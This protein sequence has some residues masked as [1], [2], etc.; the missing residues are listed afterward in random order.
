VAR[1][2]PLANIR[3]IGVVAH[4]DAGKTT[5]TERL[6]Y[7]SGRVH[8]IGEVD[9][10]SAT[11]DWMI[12][13]QER[14]ITIT[15]AATSI[16][17]RE[18]RIN[19]IDTPGHVDF[20]MEVE[21]SL[22]VLDGAIVIFCAKGGVEPQ[23]ETVWRQADRYRVPRI[24]YINKMDSVGA[25][26]DSAVD[27]MR[28]KLKANPLPVQL[29]I[30]AEG[31]FRGAVDLVEMQAL[32]FSGEM[33][34]QVDRT[35]IPAE[36]LA[37]A[38]AA[39][40]RLV[41]AV[42]EIDE[43][44]LAPYLDGEEIGADALRAA[45]RR[46]TLAVKGIP[47]FCGTSLRNKGVQPLI[48]GVVDYLPAPSDLP[49]VIG[50]HPRTEEDES[51]A[52]S[53]EEPFAALVFKI[54]TDPYVGKLS[55]IRVYS[56]HVETGKTVWNPRTRKR[57]RL[58]RLVRMHANHRA[59]ITELNTGDVVAAVG[60]RELTTGD[61]LCSENNPILLEQ[62]QYPE[63]VISVAIEPDTKAD[64]ERL[65]LSLN[66]LAEEDPTF[67]Y[68]TDQETGQQIISGMG[69]LH[70]DIIVDRLVREF[71]VAARVGRPQVSYRE[72]IQRPAQAEARYVRQTGGRGQF[73]HVELQIVPRPD[74]TGFTFKDATKGGV[75]PGE[76]LP[77]VEAG[78]REAMSAGTQGF[79][80]IG[81]DVSLVNGSAHEVDSSP[82]AFRIAASMAFRN[83]MAK[84]TPVLLE[85]MMLVEVVIPEEYLGEVLADLS[86]RRGSIEDVGQGTGARIIDATVPLSAMFGYA[87]DLRSLTQGR[88]TFTMQFARY[89]LLPPGSG[90]VAGRASSR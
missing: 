30:G 34:A 9:Q 16:E 69:E 35:E 66:K 31:D 14:G 15:S 42:A 8:R 59:D 61:T 20:T 62:M 50:K 38:K 71:G 77:D 54:A 4:I 81:V 17:W 37:P 2:V 10:G 3:N 89:N 39:R 85:P 7:Y 63:P 60:M 46:I 12:Q 19:V 87:T 53:D 28:R 21:R 47:V 48:D 36:Y 67:R 70:L 49:P 40:E 74:L 26:F 51:R 6:L 90:P 23:S 79:P 84:A 24:A 44:I 76:F 75:V 41:E 72:T 58:G 65:S 5:T 82:I 86:Q 45:L 55:Y 78:V 32:E 56:G 1:V 25:S 83:A 52:P 57:E 22:R 11:M 73:G 68:H 43:E 13:E 80:V 29:P 33:G 64:E 27:S 88:G 18:F